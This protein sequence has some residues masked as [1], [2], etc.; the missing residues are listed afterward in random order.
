MWYEVDD[1]TKKYITESVYDP[2]TNIKVKLITYNTPQK[3]DGISWTLNY[4]RITG[5]MI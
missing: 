4:D 3:S 2:E 1:K 5:R